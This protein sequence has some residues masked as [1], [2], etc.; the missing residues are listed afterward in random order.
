M[1]L[2]AN[3][4]QWINQW[5][6]HA[7][8]DEWA[9]IAKIVISILG[10]GGTVI[11]LNRAYQQYR[12]SDQ[13]KR[14]EFIAKEMRELESNLSI[15]NALHMVDW[16]SRRIN[17]FLK[18]IP[19]EQD[20]VKIT[21]E[22]QWRALLPHNIKE[23]FKSISKDPVTMAINGKS[24]RGTYTPVEAKIRDS[25]DD[26]LVNFERF[27]NFLNSGLIKP[28]EIKPYLRYW[29]ES[30][31]KKEDKFSEDSEWR[32]VLIAYIKFYGYEGVISLF[33]KIGRNIDTE[34]EYFHKLEDL[35]KAKNSDLV[36]KVQEALIHARR[37]Q[38]V[39]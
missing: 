17:L 6:N 12:R 33:N 30:I 26:L 1:E 31:A 16:G 25:Y 27:S 37:I 39:T 19:T 10:F 34:G 36:Q 7:N 23:D 2:M 3:F 21:R 28:D 4:N 13:W 5:I 22:D 15:K 8:F 38:E 35:V 9:E 14:G 32:Y 18:P 11:T 24:V 29:V 20:Y